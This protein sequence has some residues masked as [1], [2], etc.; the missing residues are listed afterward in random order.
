MAYPTLLT[1]L[2]A[3]PAEQ[4]FQGPYVFAG[5]RFFFGFRFTD[6]KITVARSADF[7]VTWSE[8]DAANAR[9]HGSGGSLTL[10]TLATAADSAYPATPKIYVVYQFTDDLFRLATFDVSTETWDAGD[11]QST[12]GYDA[13]APSPNTNDN[14]W[15]IAHRAAD[16]NVVLFV[17]SVHELV[18]TTN[19]WRCQYAL[20]D[21]TGAA[22]SAYTQ[23]GTAG[24]DRRNYWSNACIAGTGGLT[25]FFFRKS[26]DQSIV[27]NHVAFLH[28]SLTS[29]GALSANQVLIPEAAGLNA[30]LRRT[31]S[32]ISR[33]E[34]GS[35]VIYLP[36]R[37][38][39]NTGL[40]SQVRLFKGLS[41]AVPAWTDVL[42]FTTP[43]TLIFGLPN[44]AVG[45]F[46]LFDDNAT[47]HGMWGLT[48]FDGGGNPISTEIRQSLSADGVTWPADTLFYTGPVGTAIVGS[49]VG[50]AQ[51]GSFGFAAEFGDGIADDILDY[52]D[53]AGPSDLEIVC[54]SPPVG[55]VGIPY[56]HT[57]PASGGTPPYT[58]SLFAGALPPGLSWKSVV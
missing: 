51:V 4:Q 26:A 45:P 22:W 14:S 10:G 38:I 2:N 1:V 50:G 32:P 47:L 23:V 5:V 3:V 56:S 40:N 53:S 12:L 52:W 24:G 9:A 28:V 25:H 33:T 57:F 55:K 21:L 49:N 36:Y 42:L 39:D 8:A 44:P 7:G 58:F 13:G 35:L 48:P 46:C 19:T 15:F 18:V 16:N 30:N 6:G 43:I 37:F 17:S 34:S 31:S 27:D 41:A 54:N 20:C 29:G 11:I